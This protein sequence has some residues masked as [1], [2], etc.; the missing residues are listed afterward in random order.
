MP[1]F[2]CRTCG[3]QYDEASRPPLRC[4]VCDDERQYVGPQGQVW[5]TPAALAASH[6]LRIADDDGLLGIGIDPD[7]AIPQRAL[8][9]PTAHGNLL[10]ECV[11]LVTEAALDELSRR[12]GVDAMV[13][14]HPHFYTAMVD[15]S[16]ALGGVPIFLHA[17]DRDW[18]RRPSPA[19]EFWEGEELR[20]SDAVRL[21]RLGG[22]FP[23][24]T[25][26]HWR[27]GPHGGG[28]LFP[29]DAMQ[30]VP[31]RRH[32]SFMYSYPNLMPLPPSDVRRMRAAVAELEFA[33]VYGYTWGRNLIGDGH[34]AVARSFRRYLDAVAA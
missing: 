34:A 18:V 24:S 30:V 33:D 31:D 6:H 27:D 16:D 10:W 25:A 23:G 29:G 15:W 14:S 28:A 20:L 9:L 8:L 17:A 32:V 22:H 12:G 7:F 3:T 4:P 5:T 2:I 11:S 21:L 26:L 19:I 1:C 13:I